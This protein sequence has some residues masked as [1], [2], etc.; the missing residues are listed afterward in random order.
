MGKKF[1]I[2]LATILIA[3]TCY[4]TEIL[5]ESYQILSSPDNT[6]QMKVKIYNGDLIYSVESDEDTLVETSKMGIQL[7]DIDNKYTQIVI[8]NNESG[9]DNYDFRENSN[10]VSD[11]F[12][13]YTLKASGKKYDLRIEVKI[14]ENGIAFRYILPENKDLSI[15]EEETRFTFPKDTI[16]WY[17][18]DYYAM[19]GIYQKKLV[20]DFKGRE[21]LA[22]LPTFELPNNKG[23][24]ALSEGDLKDFPGIAYK[25]DKNN[26]FKAHYWAENNGFNPL[27][28]KTPWRLFIISKDLNGLVNNSIAQNVSEPVREDLKDTDWIVPGKAVWFHD[29]DDSGNLNEKEARKSFEAC[30]ELGIKYNVIGNNWRKWGD[31]IEDALEKVKPMIELAKEYDIGMFIG[32]DVPNLDLYPDGDL[33]NSENRKH[34]LKLA[35]E[36]GVVGIKFGHI[37]SEN[38]EAINIYRE[39]VEECADMQLLTVFHNANKPTGLSRTYPNLLTREAIKGMQYNLS[40]TNNTILPFTRLLT[41]GADYTPVNFTD[42]LRIGDGSWSHMLA[43][44]VIMRSSLLTFIESPSNLLQ[45]QAAE[46]FKKLPVTW[47]ETIVLDQSKIGELAAFARKKDD[48]WFIAVQNGAGEEKHLE[49]PLSF[50]DNGFK[51]ESKEYHDD[52]KQADNYQIISSE[53]KTG[54]KLLIDLRSGGG[55]VLR[56]DKVIR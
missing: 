31:S 9:S 1:L 27:T 20:Q 18:D 17:Q 26:T 41:G 21:I 6:L 7:Q 55:C 53:Y 30:Q 46:W 5:A 4:W 44:T 3:I 22:P 52:M 24:I 35:K 37:E 38:I 48:T 25:S 23:Y 2:F 14:W 51:Y 11:Q 16:A 10:H 36:A 42:S 39:I 29:Y 33:Y 19:Q 8:E 47:D 43:N 54:D 49:I 28:N 34:F 32:H 45:N 50:L 13:K 40:A 15:K 56:L 12:E